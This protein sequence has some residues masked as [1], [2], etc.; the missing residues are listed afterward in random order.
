[1][2]GVVEGS[3]QAEKLPSLQGQQRCTRV[4][5]ASRVQREIAGGAPG[6]AGRD[7]V[8]RPLWKRGAGSEVGR[9]EAGTSAPGMPAGRATLRVEEF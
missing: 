7:A 4:G 3:R 5:E 8:A 9:A 6:V 2:V 1:M